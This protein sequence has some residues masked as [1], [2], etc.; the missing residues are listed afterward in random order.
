VLIVGTDAARV[1]TELLAGHLAC[2]DCGEGLRP[3]GQGADREVRQ[4]EGT[5]RRRFRRSICSSCSATHVLVPED[6]LLRR[7]DGVAV[8]GAALVARAKGAGHRT[9]ARALG[10]PASTVRGWLRRFAMRAVVVREHVVRWAAAI[11]A[12]FDHRGTGRNPCSD[13]VEA[14]GVLGMVSVRRFGPREVWSLVSV[15]TGGRLLANTSSPFP[16][17]V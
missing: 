10:R 11:D 15:V 16:A 13:A 7:R 8:I 1:E 5:E 9:I 6:T 17:P 12:T 4:L 2:P 14:I 3:W